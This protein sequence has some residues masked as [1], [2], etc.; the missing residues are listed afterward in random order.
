M[1]YLNQNLP[2]ILLHMHYL[3]Q[4]ITKARRKIVSR[5]SKIRHWEKNKFKKSI[6]IRQT[7]LIA[8]NSPVLNHQISLRVISSR[9]I[10]T[11]II[12][13]LSLLNMSYEMVEE[14]EKTSS[15]SICLLKQ[16]EFH[17]QRMS[18]NLVSIISPRS[19]MTHTRKVKQ[20]V[21][22]KR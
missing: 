22:L 18:W 3:L 21:L 15:N 17:V 7:K 2:Q 14:I 16:S 6:F 13:A 9:S 1:I 19:T 5:C 11:Q 10:R 20:K 12:L 4:R 8:E